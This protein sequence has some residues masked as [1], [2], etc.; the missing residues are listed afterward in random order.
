M[1]CLLKV[2]NMSVDHII[3]SL[4]AL[5]FSSLE[6]VRQHTIRLLERFKLQE[7]SGKILSEVDSRGHS[8]QVHF[9]ED[10]SGLSY[11]KLYRYFKIIG[12]SATVKPW[13]EQK[14]M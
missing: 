11:L 7:Q 12:M 1:T 3:S 10:I 14:E 5:D 4:D 13:I 6:K 2:L 8:L 9:C